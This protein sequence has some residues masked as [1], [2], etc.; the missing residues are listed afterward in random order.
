MRD[1]RLEAFLVTTGWKVRDLDLVSTRMLERRR[2]NM[3]QWVRRRKLVLLTLERLVTVLLMDSYN[4]RILI[5]FSFLQLKE[6][7]ARKKD[8][9]RM[10][11]MSSKH[12]PIAIFLF[13]SVTFF[14]P[15]L[16]SYHYESH[17]WDSSS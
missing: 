3:A 6:C 14:F 13:F 7:M 9:G 11:L 17:L 16:F 1:G 15:L 5:S 10:M 12:V 2:I 4:L 8:W